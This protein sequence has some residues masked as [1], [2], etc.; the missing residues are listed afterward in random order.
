MTTFYFAKETK[1]VVQGTDNKETDSR[2]TD[3]AAHNYEALEGATGYHELRL[4]ASQ[5]DGKEST[6]TEAH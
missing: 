6:P 5:P 2:E 3:C 4:R 1:N